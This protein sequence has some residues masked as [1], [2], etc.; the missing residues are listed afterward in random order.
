MHSQQNLEAAHEM[1]ISS[2]VQNRGDIDQTSHDVVGRLGSKFRDESIQESPSLNAENVQ[3]A[4][5]NVVDTNHDLVT[6]TKTNDV[7]VLDQTSITQLLPL[8]ED[9]NLRNSMQLSKNE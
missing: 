8:K 5:R 9:P 7:N 6:P 4:D 2:Q 3:Q 1:V